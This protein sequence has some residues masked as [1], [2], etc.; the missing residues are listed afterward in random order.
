MASRNLSATC[1]HP[2]LFYGTLFISLPNP[3]A[4]A[5]GLV[6]LA[7]VCSYIWTACGTR[8]CNSDLGSIEMAGVE[9]IVAS[10]KE[11]MAAK[12]S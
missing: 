1:A 7:Q 2:S 8:I 5:D 4:S 6:E 10:V 11:R 9:T 3:G 12:P